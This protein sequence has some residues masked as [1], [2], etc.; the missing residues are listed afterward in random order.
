MELLGASVVRSSTVDSADFTAPC[1]IS[2][3]RVA[4]LSISNDSLFVIK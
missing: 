3:N 1:V 4:S 2:T